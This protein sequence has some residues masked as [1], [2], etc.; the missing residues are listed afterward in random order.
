MLHRELEPEVMDDPR[1]AR[2][3]DAMD[4]AAVN[5]Q[6]VVDFLQEDQARLQRVLDVGTGTALIPIELCTQHPHC[7]V[8]GNDA[9]A[10]MLELGNQ[11]VAAA[12]LTAR[13]EL[14][15]GDAKALAYAD[16]S[17]DG[18]ISNS[19]IHHVAEPQWAIFQMV[20]VLR[21][22][23]RLFIRDLV[24]P[25]TLIEL[26]QLVARHAAHE[27]PA[28][29]QLLRQSLHA[30]LTLEEV[31]TLAAQVGLPADSVQLTSDRHWTLSAIKNPL[32]AVKN[33]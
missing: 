27:T 1:E 17:F 3:Y 32:S 12:G 16:S 24:R 29:Q 26:E 31:R 7:T 6:F 4:H 11:H 28:N 30:A 21:P 25:A 2:D 9:A 20:R 8:I 14:H 10:S 5:R 33:L 15:A 13:I 18:V 19:L 22:G 23:G